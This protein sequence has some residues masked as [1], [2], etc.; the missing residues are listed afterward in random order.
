MTIGIVDDTQRTAARVVGA[1]YVVALIPAVF[2]EFYVRGQLLV[3][4]NAAQTAL[5]V[6]AHERLFRLGIASNLAVF[7]IDIAL[8]TALYVVLNPINRSLALAH[9]IHE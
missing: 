4:G 8:I 5:N 7:A 2:T 9:I 6:G 1:T 3:S